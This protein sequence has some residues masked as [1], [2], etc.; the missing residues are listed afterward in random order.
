MSKPVRFEIS[1]DI[2]CAM[3]DEVTRAREQH[4]PLNS[5]HEGYAVLKEE[6]DELWDAVKAKRPE[7][8]VKEA[9][10]VG[11]MAIRF[12]LDLPTDDDSKWS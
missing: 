5:A 3:L 10:Q 11:A 2:A 1:T 9:I 4:D 12:V 6:L 8:A 7:E